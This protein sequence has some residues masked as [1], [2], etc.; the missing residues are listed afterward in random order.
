V[1]PLTVNGSQQTIGNSAH[2][3]GLGNDN[4][5]VVLAPA[6]VAYVASTETPVAIYRA[7][8]GVFFR[9]GEGRVFMSMEN[10]A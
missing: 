4:F 9:V 6:D 3:A 5:T 8:E 7:N 2:A 10:N 1:I